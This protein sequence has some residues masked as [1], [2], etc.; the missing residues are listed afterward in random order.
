MVDPIHSMARVSGATMA[1]AAAARRQPQ[2][3]AVQ[4]SAATAA[5]LT[6]TTVGPARRSVS[7]MAIW[8]AA[9][10]T[11]AVAA[12]AA[13]G[14]HVRARTSRAWAWL[15]PVADRSVR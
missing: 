4:H 14:R 1:R 11:A 7:G 3:S 10:T 2:A 13:V 6:A 15:R 8:A 9:M 5:A 12:T